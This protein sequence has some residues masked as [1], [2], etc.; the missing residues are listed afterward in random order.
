M[1]NVRMFRFS[2]THELEEG[3]GA[4]PAGSTGYQDAPIRAP[5]ELMRFLQSL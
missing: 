2:F 5:D 4:R 1:G 3:E